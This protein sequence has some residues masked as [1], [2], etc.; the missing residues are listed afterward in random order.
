MNNYLHRWKVP[1]NDFTRAQSVTLR[2]LMSHTGGFNVWGFPDFQPHEKLPTLIETLDGLPPEKTAPIRVE[3]VPGAQSRYSGGGV[4][5][6][7]LVIEDVTGVSFPDAARKYLLKPLV[8]TRSTFEN[9]LPERHGNIAKAHNAKGEPVAL[10][11]GFETMPE[12]AASGLWTT[13]KDY[14]KVIIAI[15]AAWRGEANGIIDH[16]LAEEM[17][18][19]VGPGVSGLGAFLDGHGLTR[20]FSHSGANDSYK[21]WFEGHLATGD[22]V[23]IMTNGASEGDLRTEV[24]RAVALAEGWAPAFQETVH[25]PAVHVSQADIAA[26]AGSY[27][28]DIGSDTATR[29]AVFQVLLAGYL[30]DYEHLSFKVSAE[31]GR[32]SLSSPNNPRPFKLIAEDRTHFL[33]ENRPE[34]RIEFV[35]SYKGTVDELMIKTTD[36]VLTAKRVQP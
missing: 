4:T 30:P 9:P 24:R 36:S 20:R 32:L 23:V 12:T 16:S 19:E 10:P 34:I 3:Y 29:R 17:M 35:R 27:G 11:R 26:N 2:G 21:A 6:E 13:P 7:Q 22:G 18:T 1:A 28:L 25:V 14:A 33:V 5:V 8:M 31:N 15:M